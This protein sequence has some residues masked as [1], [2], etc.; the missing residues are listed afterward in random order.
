MTLPET[1]TFSLSLA[2]LASAK[3]YLDSVLVYDSGPFNCFG[4]YYALGEYCC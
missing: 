3:I 4:I 1:I 2:E